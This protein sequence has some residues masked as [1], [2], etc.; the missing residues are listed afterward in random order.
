MHV[1][2]KVW[3]EAG[4]ELVKKTADDRYEIF[5]RQPAQAGAANKRVQQ[6]LAETLCVSAH[7]L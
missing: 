2:V 7:Q 1:K 5:V 6:L 3:P 4:K